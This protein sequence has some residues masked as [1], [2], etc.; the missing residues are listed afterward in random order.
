MTTRITPETRRAL[1]LSSDEAGRSMSQQAELLLIKALHGSDGSL[2][3]LEGVLEAVLTTARRLSLAEHGA[4]TRDSAFVYFGVIK[5]L[6]WAQE[7]LPTPKDDTRFK[8][9]VA[10]DEEMDRLRQLRENQKVGRRLDARTE[11]ERLA[12]LP[13]DEI[14]KL[15]RD[16]IA[17]FDRRQVALAS[18]KFA[19]N[20]ADQA[21]RDVLS[22]VAP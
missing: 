4:G 18:I 12:D 2:R 13:S 20:H 22:E 3:H 9:V 10:L 11:E 16:L 6:E 19:K 14:E 1:E 7:A 15:D 17:L 8:E 5:A 21:A